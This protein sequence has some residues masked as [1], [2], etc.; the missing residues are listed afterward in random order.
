MEVQKPMSQEAEMQLTKHRNL[1]NGDFGVFFW[2]SEMWQPE[3]GP[4]SARAIHRFVDLLADSGVDTFLVNPN[5]QVAWYPS[6]AIPTVLD[7]YIR[8]DPSVRSGDNWW[9][10][11][12]LNPILDLKEAG[13][14]WLAE[15]IEH[16]HERGISPWI[17][18]RMNDPHLDHPHLRSPLYQDGLL[19]YERQEVRD[20]YFSLIR[21]VVE[22][23]DSAGLEL[24]WLRCPTCCPSPASQQTIDMMTAWFSDIRKLTETKARQTGRRFPLGMRIPGSYKRMREIG[25]DVEAI[26]KAGLVDF[27]CPTNFMQTSWDMP[28]DR[29]RAEFG[30]D[31]T[32]YGVTEL[33]LNELMVYSK[34][35]DKTTAPY[36]C[37][38]VPALL[39][40]A[41]GKLVL[42]ADGMEQYNFFCADQTRKFHNEPGKAGQYNALRNLH[43]LETLRGQSKHYSICSELRGWSSEFDLPR[44]LPVIL[45]PNNQHTFTLPMCVEPADRELELIVQV[46][47]EKKKSLSE[48]GIS[49]NGATPCSDASATDELLFPNG[50]S[51]HHLSKYQAFNYRFTVSQIVEG[52]NELVVFNQGNEAVKIVSIELAVK[53]T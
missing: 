39:G 46:V 22:D 24:D 29:L 42:G 16:C 12:L 28:H 37:A 50:P 7:N 9:S 15:A 49:F 18:I 3:G 40:N 45:E 1:Y 41:A 31:I 33:M 2:N 53:S 34:E 14:D 5:S 30:E 52:W 21:E 25:I 13:V 11:D 47:V 19:N 44:P 8:D 6:R 27:V 36:V 35:L 10:P 23:Y 4:Y 26:I 38:S 17:S 48:I 20:Y 32:I 51:K 43:D